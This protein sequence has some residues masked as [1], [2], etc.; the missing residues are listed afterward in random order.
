MPF[1]AQSG[2]AA[3]VRAGFRTVG[4]ACL[5][6]CRCTGFTGC[7]LS[8]GVGR[9]ATV[10][11]GLGTDVTVR[12][13][14]TGSTDAAGVAACTTVS[15]RNRGRAAVRVGFTRRAFRAGVVRS[16]S[17]AA[18]FGGNVTVGVGL[19]GGTTVTGVVSGT[20]VSTRP[21][22]GKR[23]ARKTAAARTEKTSLSK[24]LREP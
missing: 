15:T 9:S 11:T 3:A 12:V 4:T 18:G 5:V 20:S 16:A 19:A 8:A 7:A 13:T 24:S 23:A 10:V 21:E 17:V 1:T 22:T 14:R 2:T 6:C